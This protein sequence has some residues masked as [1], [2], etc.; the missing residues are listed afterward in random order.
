MDDELLQALLVALDDATMQALIEAHT[1]GVEVIE[2][3]K[4]H[5]AGL[6]FD[7]PSDALHIATV[8]RRLGDLLPDP[9]PALGRWTLANALLFAESY[10][11]A[12]DLFDQTRADYLALGRPLDAARMGVGHVW[13]LAYIGQFER[14]LELA[15]EIE[16]VL[17][18]AAETDSA[19]RRRL[20]GLLNN[21]G[22]LYDL[23]GQYE[24]AL[25]AYDRKLEISQALGNELDVARTQ[26]NRGC[27]LTYLNAVDE[28]LAAFQKAESGFLKAEATADLARLSY[29]RGTLYA[30]WERYDT[31]EAE[32]VAAHR[33]L[34]TLE[35]TEQAR[36]ALTVYRVL[37]RLEGAVAPGEPPDL[38]LAEGLQR[39]LAAAQTILAI[40]GPLFE[41]GL[42][43]LGLGRCCLVLDDLPGAQDGFEQALAIAERGGGR[44]LAWE[45]LHNLGI[46]AERRGDPIAAVKLYERAIAHIE[47]IR[48]DLYVGAFRASYLADKLI[49]YQDLALLFVRLGR[50][51]DAFTTVE[52]AKSRLLVEQL[53]SRLSGEVDALAMS[54]DPG[55]QEL[56]HRLGDRLAQLEKLYRQAR[57]DETGERGEMWSA[58][59]DPVTLVA[60]EQ[61]EDQVLELTR[62]MERDQPML[63][64]LAI[65]HTVPL[66]H[67][68]AQL[69]DTLLLQ[70]HV[71]QRTAWVFVVNSSGVKTHE[72]LASLSEIVATQRR[73]SAAVD[74]ALGL[75]AQYGLEALT[76]YLPALLADAETQLVT[77]YDLLVRPLAAWLPPRTPLIIS[78][79]GL[80]HYVPFHALYDGTA[81]LVERHVVSY[82]PSVAVLDLCARHAAT[83]R[84][85]LVMGYGGDRLVQVNAEVEALAELFPQADVLSDTAATAARLLADA[86]RYRILHLAAHARFRA[87]NTMLSLFSLADRRLTLA[88]IARLRLGADL[89]ALSGC[90]TGRGRLY[91]ADLISLAGGFLGA[92]AR[93]LLVS[94]WRV[95]DATTAQLMSGFYRALQSGKGRAAA[96]RAAQLE[97][98]A[99]GRQQPA[100]Y[101]VYCHPA[102]WAPFVMIGEW[103]RLSGLPRGRRMTDA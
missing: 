37:V 65:G 50:L 13:A 11:E 40:H 7:R 68:Q 93:S 26:H 38:G 80:L 53:T 56:G 45:A 102:Y 8:A 77:L 88:E 33:W 91:G 6:Y 83:G 95:D 101:G 75:A 49:V 12:A 81:Y 100:E 72:E 73:F 9:A 96:L 85:M 2:A 1:L 3:L 94:L 78:P 71:A 43:W 64:P 10:Q 44:P 87:D 54:D 27:A 79:D 17:A 48:R 62:R 55:I 86:P 60:V 90:E 21:V 32:F 35:G 89:V 42:A 84:G 98:L 15:A 5:S 74:R 51:E 16:P 23:M 63:S 22:I 47:T 92:G 103:G 18:T 24:E 70:Y 34:S 52:R 58:A 36:A 99:L 30:R 19:D 39:E 4:A 59:P 67:V 29:N 25:G 66:P 57:Q 69:Q 97:L 76:R 31:A 61:L 20:G 46:L 14:G 28:A 82:T 41:E